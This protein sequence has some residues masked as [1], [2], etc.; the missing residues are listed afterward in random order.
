M[1]HSD[2]WPTWMRVSSSPVARSIILKPT[3]TLHFT[4]IILSIAAGTFLYIGA[5]DLLPEI[6]SG[7]SLQPR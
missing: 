2:D 7:I 3:R 4:A 1:N 6:H 5:T